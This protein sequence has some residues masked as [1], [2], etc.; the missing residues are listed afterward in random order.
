[1]ESVIDQFR[2]ALVKFH[3][4]KAEATIVEDVPVDA[5]GSKLPIKQLATI[6]TP[7]PSQ[8]IITPWDK[9][10]L[11]QVEAALR[12]SDLRLNP[13]NDGH[14]IR[15]TLP[16]MSVER[17]QELVKAMHRKSEEARVALRQIREEAWIE[18][19]EA[20][21]AKQLTEDDRYLGE[22]KLNKLIA[23][24]NGQIATLTDGKEREIFEF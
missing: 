23:G 4:G 9:G 11:V 10:N 5:Y 13:V 1:M 17:R 20:E 21:K 14:F 15:I 24:C 19:K 2:Q 16:P 12:L 18:V 7:E 8:I 3:T 22:E 6:S